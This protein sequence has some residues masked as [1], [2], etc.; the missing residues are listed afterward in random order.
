MKLTLTPMDI[1]NKEF[2]KGFSGYKA[3]EVDDF[4]DEVIENY[5]ELY[6]E[7]ASLK[8]KLAVLSEQIEHYTKI[9]STIQNTLLLAQNAADQAK[10]SAEKEAEMLVKN[11]NETAQ[12]I[13]DKAH[14][15]VVQIN[16]EYEN[17]KQQFIKFRAKFRN[18]MNTQLETFSDLEKDMNINYTLQNE[19]ETQE[20][21]EEIV[22]EKPVKTE[23]ELTIG[24]DV[25]FSKEA[26]KDIED[27]VLTDEIDEIKN[28]FANKENN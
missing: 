14:G 2:K 12:K 6:K 25:S 20:V 10:S 23:E 15:D 4:L 22:T 17:M 8:E 9:E 26:F 21:E 5:E 13:L 19:E 16:D 24:E 27:K 7:N 28:F 3:D 18:F 11:A 1:N